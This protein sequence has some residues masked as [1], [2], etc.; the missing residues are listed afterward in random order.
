MSGWMQRWLTAGLLAGFV[1]L[2]GVYSVVN[3]LFEAP[4]EVWHFEYVRWLAEG[5][6]LPRPEGLASPP[7]RQEGSQ[8]PL[9]Y[10]FA[11][12]LIWPL[13]ADNAALLARYNPHAA[14]GE[15]DSLDNKNMM[16]HGADEDWPWRG[17][18]LAVHL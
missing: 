11:A 2:A 15:A 18:V 17:T 7:W 16:A 10:F 4:D 9:F 5:H 1:L 12:A 8:P 6:G 13:P 14:V 3:P